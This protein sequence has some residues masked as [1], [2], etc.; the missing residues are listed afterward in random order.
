MSNRVV[1]AS[2]TDAI[3]AHVDRLYL[4]EEFKKKPMVNVDIVIDPDADDA[5][6]LARFVTA[7]R[8]FEVLGSGASRDDVTFHAGGGIQLQTDG[9]G[10]NSVIILPHLDPDQTQW[11]KAE[12]NTSQSPSIGCTMRTSSAITAM[13]IWFGLKL[14]NTD[15]VATDND[16]VFF[17]YDSDTTINGGR[18]QYITVDASRAATGELKGQDDE[19]LDTGLALAA[20]TTYK[21]EIK[22]DSGRVPT[23]YINDRAYGQG[24]AL[25]ADK[26]LIPYFG[27]LEAEGSAK[28]V[29]LFKIW[30]SMNYHD[31]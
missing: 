25:A 28:T 19:T 18:W 27:V 4:L 21:L 16:S 6:V 2:Q 3:N 11:T 17:R 15:V 8:D 23:F 9:G 10:T 30:A 22:V 29:R 26:D 13:K 31:G 24:T 12:W 7:N 5:T 1:Q 14:T 20:S